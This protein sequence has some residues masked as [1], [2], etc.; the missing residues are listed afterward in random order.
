MLSKYNNL[1]NKFFSVLLGIIII[2]ILLF[3]LPC[4]TIIPLLPSRF[5]QP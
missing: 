2:I 5:S 4:P 1:Y 3:S